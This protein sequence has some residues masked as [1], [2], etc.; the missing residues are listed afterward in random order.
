MTSV[1]NSTSPTCDRCH[2]EIDPRRVEAGYNFCMM[3]GDVLARSTVRTIVPLHKS[4]Y[5]LVTKRSELKGVNSK[6]QPS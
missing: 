6:Y 2:S 3:C 5:T 1:S 4:N